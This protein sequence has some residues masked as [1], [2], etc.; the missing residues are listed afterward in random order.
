MDWLGLAWK[1]GKALQAKER[2]QEGWMQGK[3][4]QAKERLL[5]GGRATTR[6]GAVMMMMMMM[7]TGAPKSHSTP[8][9]PLQTL[10]LKERLLEGYRKGAGVLFGGLTMVF[11]W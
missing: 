11:D 2:L 10:Q 3:A 1:E 5:E 4:L 7:M 8:V 6:F 9:D